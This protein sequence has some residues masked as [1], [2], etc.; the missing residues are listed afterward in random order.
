MNSIKFKNELYEN[1]NI[2]NLRELIDIAAANYGKDAAFLVKDKPGGEYRPISYIAF[3]NDINNLGTAL[4]DLGL[5]NEKIA[6]IGENR[7]EWVIS[8]LAVTNG[9]GV[10]VPIDKE[11]PG[12]EIKNLVSRSGAKA[13]I[14]SSKQGKK[15]LDAVAGMSELKYLISMDS[16]RED[17]RNKS[18]SAL[19]EKGKMLIEVNNDISYMK[20]PIEERKLCSIIYTSGTT[21]MAKGVMLS[22][23]NITANMESVSQYVSYRGLTGL[24]VLPMHHTYEFNCHILAAIHQGAT[25]AMCEGL[26]HVVKNMKEAGVSLLVGVPLLFE[27]MHRRIWKKAEQNGKDKKLKKA[28]AI[29]KRLEKRNIKAMRKFY[30]DIYEALGGQMKLMITGAAAIN[31]K[32]VEDFNAFGINMIQG[33]GMTENSPIISVNKDR[34]SKAASAGLPL[35]GLEVKIDSPD[36]NGIGEIICK[37]DTVMLGYYDDPEETD[38]VLRDGWLYTGDIGYFDKDGFLYIS[39]RKKNV[40]VTKNGKNIFPEEV[41]F[42]LLKSPYIKEVVVWGKDD[43]KTGDT[44]LYA[45]V[46]PDYEVIEENPAITTKEDVKAVIGSEIDSAND[47]M[48]SYKR[49]KRFN[50]R[51]TEFEKTTT[52]K[53]KRFAIT[54]QNS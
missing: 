40:I 13:L 45:D 3:R 23:K 30:K 44:V 47:Q 34:Y 6:V 53:I 27:N 19:L 29:S 50:L 7:Y 26:K 22:H 17:D 20:R 21:G 5:A 32:V 51:D 48:T 52:Q 24:S 43:E 18:L 38:K 31:P 28:M 16:Q 39:G 14:Y 54:N 12:E 42:I 8:Y 4:L 1:L 46:F 2:N 41:E 35:P 25:I 15:V 11:L 10:I 37:G 33:Y 49:V 9:V 36:A